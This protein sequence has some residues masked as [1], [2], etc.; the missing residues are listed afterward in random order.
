MQIA[1]H[2]IQLLLDI[3]SRENSIASNIAFTCG[4]CV[5]LMQ[6]QLDY[7]ILTSM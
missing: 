7:S 2:S 1:L 3:E 5:K 4:T 6:L